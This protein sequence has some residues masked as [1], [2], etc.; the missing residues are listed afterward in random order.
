MDRVTWCCENCRA[1]NTHQRSETQAPACH[2]CESV[3]TWDG[4][5]H[6][7]DDFDGYLDL[8]GRRSVERFGADPLEAP[9]PSACVAESML[10]AMQ[11]GFMN[12][13]TVNVTLDKVMRIKA[14]GLW[15]ML[16]DVPVSFCGE[17]LDEPFLHFTKG[18][19]VYDVWHWFEATFELSVATDL[20]GL[21]EPA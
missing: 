4:V 12:G 10:N 16:G 6:R 7:G 20:M 13:D 2:S 18:D 5:E 1:A 19:S 14:K 8:F 21:G 9:E 17:R 11:W 15:K 3:F